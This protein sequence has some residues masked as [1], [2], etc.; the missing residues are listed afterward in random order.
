MFENA[1]ADGSPEVWTWYKLS[2]GHW[3]TPCKLIRPEATIISN[4]WGLSNISSIFQLF[5]SFCCKETKPRGTDKYSLLILLA[6]VWRN[7]LAAEKLKL[8]KDVILLVSPRATAL[9]MFL[10]HCTTASM[11]KKKKSSTYITEHCWR[12]ISKNF[13]TAL[14]KWRGAPDATESCYLNFKKGLEMVV[15]GIH[16]LTLLL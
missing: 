1:V 8:K 10:Q 11:E 13:M 5:Q 7:I 6:S 14:R 12:L 15:I 2:Q 16:Q 9:E 4:N 3:Q